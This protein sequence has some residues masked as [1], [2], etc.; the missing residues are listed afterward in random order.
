LD[1]K[2][3]LERSPDYRKRYGT[4]GPP[5][6]ALNV[7]HRYR[8]AILEAEPG[9]GGR[10][11]RTVVL[12]GAVFPHR[13]AEGEDFSKGKLWQSFE[14]VGVGAVPLL[15][16][17][18]EYLREWVRKALRAGGWSLADRVMPHVAAEQAHVWRT[19]AAEP[20]LVG[21]LRTD[22]RE[23]LEWIRQRG[24]YYLPLAKDQPRQ[25]ATRLLA[26][27]VPADGENRGAVRL[28][29]EIRGVQT[30]RRAAIET[31]WTSHRDAGEA[32]LLYEV[33]PVA[34][35]PKPI[36]NRSGDGRGQRF[37][38]HRW[39]SRL[40]LDRAGT[41]PEL[42]LE[43]EAEWRLHE[44]LQAS[45]MAFEVVAA[46]VPRAERMDY[47]GH[48]LFSVKGVRQTTN[49][50]YFGSGGF[51]IDWDEGTAEFAASFQEV[52]GLLAAR[53]GHANRRADCG[54]GV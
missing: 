39:T 11:G 54:K 33:G 40:A 23:H 29:A 3:R 28:R 41:V 13:E 24:F 44:E 27:Y 17:S 34:D 53:N 8:D 47:R 14:R 51:R 32:Y 46:A 19:A 2:Y 16:G 18:T 4:E 26:I 25:Y 49:V 35:L 7:L 15:P 45:G 20:V 1:A 12:A 50:R 31:P 52:M 36:E 10:A 21:V 30:V 37:S 9:A 6:D 22:W 43:T 48:A 42:L 38:G 5:E